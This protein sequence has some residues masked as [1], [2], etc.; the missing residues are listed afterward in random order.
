MPSF[1]APLCAAFF[2]AALLATSSALAAPI[3]VSGPG[4]CRT[5]SGLSDPVVLCTRAFGFSG[6]GF[7]TAVGFPGG[8]GT[9][10]Q[11][12]TGALADGSTSIF[13]TYGFATI[14]SAAE[15]FG[16][17]SFGAADVTG[18]SN[19]R[20][21][22]TISSPGLAGTA[23]VFQAAVRITLSEAL[24]V[25]W[26]SGA[27]GSAFADRNFQ[28][29]VTANGR[30]WRFGGSRSLRDSQAL[31]LEET[32]SGESPGILVTGDLNFVFGTPFTLES[33]VA[34]NIE[35]SASG[36]D[37]TSDVSVQLGYQWYGISVGTTGFAPVEQFTVTS[38]SGTDYAGVV[39]EPSIA[40]MLAL[41]LAG[42]HLRRRG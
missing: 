9:E 4:F 34:L 37:G 14:D 13:G 38:A 19:F 25:E 24:L 2:A 35:A 36:P 41:G 30:G 16:T 7:D 40:L 10:S 22:V 26:N 23:G 1:R 8:S 6:P 29:Q 17:S 18:Y 5:D 28:F 20:D 32:L 12:S 15:K 42:A 3:F 39:P 21:T 31:G 11:S 27:N 33:E